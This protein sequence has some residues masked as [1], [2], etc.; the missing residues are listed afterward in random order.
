VWLPTVAANGWIVLTKDEA[1]QRGEIEK[2][3]IRNAK[4]RVFILVRGDLSARDGR[5]F[6][7]GV[8]SNGE[9]YWKVSPAIHRKG[10]PCW[11]SLEN[12]F[13]LSRNVLLPQLWLDSVPELKPL[14][15]DYE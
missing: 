3:A 8:K 2:I 1:M 12:R 15:H 9:D 5:D 14:R 10:L 7:E 4:A 13:D 11:F 6:C